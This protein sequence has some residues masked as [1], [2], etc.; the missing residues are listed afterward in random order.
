M[1][2]Q[3]AERNDDCPDGAPAHA[4]ASDPG[5]QT[6]QAQRPVRLLVV[7]DEEDIEALFR[8]RFR[9]ELR[10]GDYVLSFSSD[11]I[12]ALKMVD[13]NPDLEV[14]ITD[15]N[16][17]Q[18]NG[19]ELLTEVAKF[20]RPLKTIVLTAYNDLGNIRA[21]MMR[22]A[23]DFQVKPLDV[24]DLQATISK[25]VAM[26]RQLQ[27]G[28]EA[29]RHASEL[30]RQN[31]RVEDIFGRYVSEEVKAHL[32]AC[33]EGHQGGERRTLTVLMADIRG[34]TRMSETLSPEG[35]VQVLNGYLARA[36]DVIL[37]WN[38]TIN[39]ILGDGL[40]V[41]FGAPISDGIA[42][43]HAVAAALELQLAMNELNA[44]HR[45]QGLP[46]LAI[47]IG[48]HT[49]EAVVGT[50]G[51][52]RRQ[53]YTAIGKNVNLVARIEAHTVGGQVLVSDS[54]YGEICDIASTL[55][56]FQVQV[57]GFTDPVVVH[58]VRGLAG[59]YDIQLPS[60]DRTLTR[61]AEPRPI[62]VALIKDKI[63]GRRH[64][65]EVIASG[66]EAVR[67]RT[68]LVVSPFDDLMLD[69]AG[70]EVFAKVVE[71]DVQRGVCDLLAVYTSVTDDVRR[72]LIATAVVNRAEVVRS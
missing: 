61:L 34:F 71:C 56:S 20:Q 16:M 19:L 52:R 18:M 33:P 13:E 14:L 8:G 7:D 10:R 6:V 46:E 63:V 5:T 45:E 69:V 24:E 27:D 48:V 4:A 2:A 41:F 51:S 1:Q 22:G 58:D 59:M 3:E 38:G 23:F 9:K 60:A 17:P 65:A 29:R 11:P 30:A 12:Q 68:E 35:V 15:L 28:E 72:A 32:L 53:K 42:T 50:I 70:G 44:S 66:E 54:A 64:P 49:G 39:E 37:R 55:G 67:I 47:G 36:T 26:V 25:A 40:L 43:Q 21:A 62:D 31:R 57:K